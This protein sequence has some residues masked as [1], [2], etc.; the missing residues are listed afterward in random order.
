MNEENQNGHNSN[1]N[2]AKPPKNKPKSNG[3]NA[4]QKKMADELLKNGGNATA[5]YKAAGYETKGA[6]ANASRLIAN[7]KVRAYIAEQAARAA[8]AYGGVTPE[9]VLGAL[10]RLALY[11]PAQL[12]DKR[13]FFDYK[14]CRRNG[15]TFVI[16][17]IEVTERHSERQM[18]DAEGKVILDGDGKPKKEVVAGRTTVKYK[19]H[20]KQA[21]LE[22][23][24]RAMGLEKEAA[25]NPRDAA[26]AALEKLK[27]E[28][29]DLEPGKH[30]QI[31]AKSHGVPIKD[32]TGDNQPA[33]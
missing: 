27:Q 2:G 24:M 8:H 4:R 32:L 26:R 12:L 14:K 18:K 25:K 31:I 10:A 28:F 30:E 3:L 5:A 15:L 7:D 1:G 29:P 9:S 13:G 33:H 17:E 20:D 11:D 19:L 16:K 6:S 22:A 23:L 21:P